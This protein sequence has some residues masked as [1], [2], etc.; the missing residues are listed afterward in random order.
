MTIKVLSIKQIT[1]IET[2][3]VINQASATQMRSTGTSSTRTAGLAE[4]LA[5]LG[6]PILKI[7]FAF[8]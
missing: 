8:K 1:D 2:T 6:V 7:V 5:L 3:D 4:E